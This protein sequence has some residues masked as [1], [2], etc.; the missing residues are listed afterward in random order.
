MIADLDEVLCRWHHLCI[1]RLESTHRSEMDIV[2]VVSGQSS[3]IALHLFILLHK[4]SLKWQEVNVK[5]LKT[6]TASLPSLNSWFSL[7]H[8]AEDYQYCQR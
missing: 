6:D 1:C 7:A 8:K 3:N 4:Q 5:Q 2:T